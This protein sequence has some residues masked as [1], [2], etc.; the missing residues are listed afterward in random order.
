MLNRETIV[1]KAKI[2]R[3]ENYPYRLSI[4]EALLIRKMEPSIN[5]QLTCINPPHPDTILCVTFSYYNF[6]KNLLNYNSSDP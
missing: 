6:K 4:L 1:N 2:L 3:I 5:K